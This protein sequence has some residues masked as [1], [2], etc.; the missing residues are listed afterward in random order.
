MVMAM[1]CSVNHHTENSIEKNLKNKARPLSNSSITGDQYN[2]KINPK[3]HVYPI[4]WRWVWVRLTS[5]RSHRARGYTFINIKRDQQS[6][7]SIHHLLLCKATGTSGWVGHQG[8]YI[9]TVLSN[10]RTNPKASKSHNTEPLSST[11]NTAAHSSLIVANI[12][13]LVWL[14][15]STGKTSG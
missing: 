14:W 2:F 4:M 5:S 10:T 3:L 11:A 7:S 6:G 9:T 8:T 13:Y 15:K 12:L 1:S